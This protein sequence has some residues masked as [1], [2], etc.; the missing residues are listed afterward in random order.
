MRDDGSLVWLPQLRLLLHLSQSL[1]YMLQFCV[2]HYHHPVVILVAHH[3]VYI[4]HVPK[5][6]SHF[7]FAIVT[8][9]TNPEIHR[10]GASKLLLLIRLS[11]LLPRIMASVVVIT[12]FTTP[13]ILVPM[14]F[15]VRTTAV[16]ILALLQD[17]LHLSYS[18]TLLAM[19]VGIFQVVLLLKTSP[20]ELITKI[21]SVG[22]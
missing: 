11:V 1:Q 12:A 9:Q 10:L 21:D 20:V 2:S 14:V 15:I 5:S 18:T 6:V 17:A 4:I 8:A 7:S 13:L 22:S 3:V 16:V 19:R